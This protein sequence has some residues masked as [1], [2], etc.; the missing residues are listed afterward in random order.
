M[1]LLRHCDSGR[2][3]YQ[4]RNVVVFGPLEDKKDMYD[5]RLAPCPANFPLYLEALENLREVFY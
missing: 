3:N 4:A 2:A 5:L 1:H